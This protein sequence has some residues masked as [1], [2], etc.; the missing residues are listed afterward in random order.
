[1]RCRTV[2]IL[3]LDVLAVVFLL[4]PKRI[5]FPICLTSIALSAVQTVAGTLIGRAYPDALG[6]AMTISREAR[7][8]PVREGAVELAQDPV[9]SLLMLL[10]TMAVYGF[11]TVVLIR[12]RA[13]FT[14]AP[15]DNLT[16]AVA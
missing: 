12:N 15:K 14:A 11:L 7:G 10:A 16:D 8:L 13:Y 3:I 9:I 5:G 1:M 6:S 4:R 2:V